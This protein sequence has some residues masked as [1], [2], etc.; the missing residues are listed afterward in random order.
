MISKDKIL[1]ILNDWNFW[2]KE[3]ETGLER[4]EYLEKMERYYKMDL[5]ISLVGIRRSGKSTLMLQFA[6]KLIEEKGISKNNIL[7]V[8]FEDSR[9]LGE[10]SL[11]LLNNIYEIY[12]E[13]LTPE[14][15]PII[16]LDEAQNIEGWEKFV[17][18][19]NERKEAKIFV[20]GSNSHLLSSEFSTVLTGRQL[21]LIIYPLSFEEFLLFN[22]IEIT[23]KLDLINKQARVKKAFEEYLEF[24]GMPKQ[25]FLKNS[26]DKFLLLRNYFEDILSRDLIYRFKIRQTEK[27]KTLAKFYFSNESS[28]ISFNGIAKFLKMPL[29]TIERFS[30]Y[31]TYPYLIYFVS[32]FSFSLKEQAVNPR[33][34][35]I[36]DLGLRNAVSFDFSE[37]KG[38]LLENLVF[39]HLLKTGKEIY[40]Y[41][42]KNNLEVDFLLKEKQK[43]KSL[44]QVCLTLKDFKTKDR[45]I[46][47]LVKAMQELELKEGLILTKDEEDAIEVDGKKIKVMPVYKWLLEKIIDNN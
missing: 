11:D 35:Y 40:Y 18:S 30:E 29:S 46:D 42:T 24:G 17:R 41:K 34:V 26:D 16:F 37:N 14:I 47:S 28:L 43:I 21:P 2:N 39:L 20:S 25:V 44:I 45:E 9:F 23:G 4:K 31:L 3:I 36:S 6:K 22:K 32:K 12:L 19:L 15:K 1:E 7:Y 33:K 27:L 5:V 8:N 13:N 10:Y 38:K